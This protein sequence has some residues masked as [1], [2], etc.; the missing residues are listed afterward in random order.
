MMN[1]KATDRCKHC[2]DEFANHNYVPGSQDVF[3]CP[4]PQQH[5]GYGLFNGGDPR[6]FF[7]DR[8]ECSQQELDNHSVACDFWNEAARRGEIPE[9][10]AY[11]FGI[12]AYTREVETRF[13]AI[14]AVA[15]EGDDDDEFW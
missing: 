6:R 10:K 3:K 9:P 7:P 5:C 12:G 15:Y 1:A 8:T 13:E 11:R 2:G 14:A 4:R